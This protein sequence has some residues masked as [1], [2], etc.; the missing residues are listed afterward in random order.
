MEIKEFKFL[1]KHTSIYG[2]GA[3]V[4][5]AASFMLLPVYT[6]YL[7]PSDYGIMSLVNISMELIGIVLGLGVSAAMARFYYDKDDEEKRKK[8]IST[9]YLLSFGFSAVGLILLFL[10]SEQ[11]SL[12]IFDTRRYTN[13]FMVGSA[14]MVFELNVEIGLA[15][16]RIKAASTRYVIVSFTRLLM[17]ISFNIL[18]VVV[19]KTGVI[20]IF[21]SSLITKATF[22]ILLTVPIL[23]TTGVA[24]SRQVAKE[25]MLFAYPLI[26]SNIPRVLVNQSDKFFINFYFTPLLTGLYTLAQRIGTSLHILM[27]APFL[28]S[29]LPHRFAIMKQDN[30]KEVYATVLRYYILTVG[31]AGLGLSIFARDIV[32]IMT[33]EKFHAASEFVPLYALGMIIFGIKYHFETGIMIRKKTKI[34]TLIN[35]IAGAVNIGL[36]FLLIA[37]Y[38]I[39]GALISLNASYLITVVLNYLFA[40]KMY[41]INFRMLHVFKVFGFAGLAYAAAEFFAPRKL[42]L[43]IGVRSLIF[44][45][46][47][48]TVVFSGVVTRE[49]L[50]LAKKK[51]HA[52][53][54][55]KKIPAEALS[56][57]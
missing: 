17:L 44:L 42:F 32:R 57:E 49:E 39:W 19:Y 47:V 21:Y 22:S 2:I 48:A 5:Q 36:N 1:L 50:A 27:T 38:K 20:G 15:Y 33:D 52:L 56:E 31:T 51:V 23:F 11:L 41:P 18:F 35:A 37:R 25:M 55:R 12:L 40:Q 54:R 8:V 14:A 29:Y 34:I 13:I 30:A 43:S 46:Y 9:S 26:F 10:S 6:R 7:S 53:V 3:I 45:A 28:A 4:S 24:F 16:M